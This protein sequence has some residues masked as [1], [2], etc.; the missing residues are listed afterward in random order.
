MGWRMEIDGELARQLARGGEF[1]L[2][3]SASPE[4]GRAIDA[5]APL[6]VS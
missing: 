4:S 6:K 1:S 3:L 5:L 2:A